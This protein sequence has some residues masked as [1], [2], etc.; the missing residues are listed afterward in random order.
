MEN[1]HLLNNNRSTLDL[2]HFACVWGVAN[3]FVE[4]GIDDAEVV[5]ELALPAPVNEVVQ[6]DVVSEAECDP[7][8][9]TQL[10][11]EQAPTEKPGDDLEGKEDENSDADDD[12]VNVECHTA[13][14]SDEEENREARRVEVEP[15]NV[16]ENV[17]EEVDS[18][19]YD[20]EDPPYGIALSLCKITYTHI[21]TTITKTII[22]FSC[23]FLFSST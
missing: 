8:V 23:L 1:L 16:G 2:I 17:N 12:L 18:Q 13:S 10:E 9:V 14:S 20:S 6:D 21:P 7:G 4:H 5:P 19:Y 15:E 11:S 3:L 22:I